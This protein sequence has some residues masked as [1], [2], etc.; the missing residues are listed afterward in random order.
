MTSEIT[1]DEIQRLKREA[2]IGNVKA[3]N[4]DTPVLLA[5]IAKVESLA[6]D[7]ER[8]DWLDMLPKQSAFGKAPSGTWQVFNGEGNMA[9]PHETLRGMIDAA[10]AKEKA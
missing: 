10:M 5:L 2:S 9:A 1:N 3:I 8:L 7:A 6:A 4:V